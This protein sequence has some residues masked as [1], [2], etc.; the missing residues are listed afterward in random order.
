MDTLVSA[1][2]VTVYRALDGGIHHARCGRRIML[3]GQRG[4]ELD[5]YCLACAE[6]VTLPLCVL[7]RIPVAGDGEPSVQERPDR[8]LRGIPRL[9][10]GLRRMAG[11]G[12]AP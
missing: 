11:V 7:S 9:R 2:I 6:S 1:E 3:Q 5:F 8:P 12:V 4:D 10:P